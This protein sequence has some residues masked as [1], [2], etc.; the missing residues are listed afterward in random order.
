MRLSLFRY[1]APD[2][3]RSTSPSI[4]I[5][6]TSL[7]AIAT[8]VN[9]VK[10]RGKIYDSTTIAYEPFA[11]KIGCGWAG[12]WS[13]ININN[14]YNQPNNSYMET[15]GNCQ[16]IAMLMESGAG[17][18]TVAVSTAGDSPEWRAGTGLAASH[19]VFS[20]PAD[21]STV[22]PAWSTCTPV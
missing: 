7:N 3:H 9:G 10:P 18:S 17:Y 4:Y 1:Q 11:I 15:H 21:L 8:C 16:S 20:L 22:D 19:Q 5:A 14:F 12:P 6:Y 2:I 13:P